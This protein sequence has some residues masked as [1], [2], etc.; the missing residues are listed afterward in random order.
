[1][2]SA[3][4]FL[5]SVFALACTREQSAPNVEAK[6]APVII[7]SVDTLRADRVG[8]M[9]RIAELRKDG[10][11]FT[12]AYSHVPLTL[13]SHV[14]LLTGLL[15][16]EHGVRNNI[17][18]PF[19]P[20]KHPTVSSILKANGYATGAAI[21]AYVLRGNTGLSKAF[22]FFDDQM[23]IRE[24]DPAGRVQRAGAET[25][26]VAEKWIGQHAQQPFFFLLHLFEPH[27]PYE[28]SYDADVASADAIAG[29]F[30]DFLKQSGV[31][32]RALIIFLSDHGEGLMD[33]GEDEHGIFVYREAI[34]VP[35]VVKLP[36]SER[37]DTNVDVP[38]QLIDI[39]PTIAAITGAKAPD[40][41]KGRSLLA[42]GNEPPR[43]IYSESLYPRF[44]LGWSDLYSVVDDQFHTI[45]APRPEVYAI[46][47]PAEKKNV[48]DENRR[49][50]AWMREELSKIPREV[51]QLGN[52]DP[53]EA[54]KLAALG[55]LS[56]SSQATGPLPDPK[57][58]IGD[59]ASMK[60]AA[61]LDGAGKRNEAIAI[62]R[63]LIERNPRL[64]DAW[65]LLGRTLERAGRLEEA[66]ETYRRGIQVA[67]SLAGEFGLS[68][69]NVYLLM[70][71]PD[72]AAEHARLGLTTNPA[73]AHIIIGRA[74]L[75]KNDIAT[76]RHEA[77]TAMQTFGYRSA[78]LVLRAQILVKQG[79]LAEALAAIDEARALGDPPAL[80][81]YVRGDAL[82]RMNRFDEAIRDFNEEI[83][84]YPG[85]RNAYASLAVV[86][87]LTGRPRDA[88]ATMERLVAANPNAGAYAVAVKTFHEMGDEASA[89][90]WRRRGAAVG[91]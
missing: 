58:R 6:N 13:P 86:Y 64:T 29:R 69:G 30:L 75:S 76:A 38:A 82:A 79:K 78:A 23:P 21:S 3:A 26:A 50:Y 61:R 42:I 47:E 89:A 71:R 46:A 90:M 28:P 68:L 48:I 70:N 32:D 7:I 59:I 4:V 8:Q 88:H 53:E 35:L 62:Y 83:R 2:R 49:V 1:M 55:Y 5:L 39:L 41:L 43:R 12:H 80:L 74:A 51:P 9:Q 77:D 66:A 20:A 22:D 11:E 15:P 84:L 31:Y 67:P 34:Q 25:V 54:K 56:S 19:D 37:A 16:P 36:K 85:D 24:G 57:D 73:S 40:G 52:I 60:E 65:T 87:M 91:R 44:H 10:I 45:E 63:Q 17:G 27:S 14:S 18:F 33:H 81:Y 72:E